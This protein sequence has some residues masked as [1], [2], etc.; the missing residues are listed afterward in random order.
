MCVW[1]LCH[2]DGELEKGFHILDGR[3]LH[4]LNQKGGES[5]VYFKVFKSCWGLS[6]LEGGGVTDI[7][8]FMC[9][10]T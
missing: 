5:S 3:L 9:A 4:F 8:L 7:L 1:I 6:P 2:P 10:V